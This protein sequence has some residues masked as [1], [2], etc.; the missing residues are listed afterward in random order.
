MMKFERV[1]KYPDAII[2][3]RSTAEAGGYDLFAAED[4]II[5][6]YWEIMG[7]MREE[8]ENGYS[9]EDILQQHPNWRPT[10]VSTGVKIKLDSDK[11]FEISARSS[12]PRKRWMIVA[13]APGK[14]DADYY[15]N[16]TN[17]GEIFVQIINLSPI[18]QI[19]KKGEKF[20]QGSIHQFF[21]VDDDTATGERQG[22]FGSTGTNV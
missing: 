16:P 9:F 5:P 13:N 11:T 12:L 8:W 22:G 19:I 10:L 7:K 20:A 3:V 1:Q 6:S 17:D 21:L 15:Q 18:D 14:V 2:P 4:T